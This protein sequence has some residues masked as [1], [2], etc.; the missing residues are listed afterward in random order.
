MN[1]EELAS[2]DAEQENKRRLADVVNVLLS[3][4]PTESYVLREGPT[5][6]IVHEAQFEN[7]LSRS[8]FDALYRLQHDTRFTEVRELKSDSPHSIQAK[9]ADPIP[10]IESVE[11]HFNKSG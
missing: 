9:L 7:S 3:A 1:T 8:Y 2:Y 11:V 10:G 4:V 5:L 6:K